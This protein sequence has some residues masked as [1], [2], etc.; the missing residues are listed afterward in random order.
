MIDSNL[1]RQRLVSQRIL[2]TSFENPGD[3]V[4]W[5]GAIQAQDYLAALWAVGVRMNEATEAAIEKAIADRT[6]IRTYP[7]RGT[8]HFVAAADARWILDL[9]APRIRANNAG[10]RRN[11]EL[12]DLVLGRSKEVVVHA[13]QGG[14][15]LTRNA[16]FRLL[17]KAHISTAGGR[18]LQITWW[19]A[20][21]GLIC[22]G[23]RQG[24]QQTFVLLDE[25]IPQSQMLERDEAL[26]ELAR[27]YFT[28]RGP[29]TLADFAWWS[30]LTVAD[31]KS[32][33]EMAQAH[34][35]QEMIGDRAYYRSDSLP[36]FH[37]LSE[38][39]ALL[40]AY[41][42]F[43]IAYADRSAFFDPQDARKLITENGIF[44]P[45]VVINGEM[46][47]IWKRTFVKETL[48]IT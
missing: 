27:R 18:G 8:L 22:F 36:A 28:S 31:A 42:E 12:D 39:A 34:L 26:A 29:A 23:L 44:R 16:L 30:G 37:D 25:W 46:V 5:L 1:A 35:V 32:G 4:A 41:D 9:L 20:H 17:E 3:V 40:P 43:T 45:T 6:I 2:H 21:E 13:L 33:I 24:K 19:L 48:E 47:G 14:N 38:S 7:L 15:R 10:R 11:F